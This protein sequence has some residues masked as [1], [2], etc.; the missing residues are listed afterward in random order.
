MALGLV[1]DTMGFIRYSHIYEGNIRDSKTLK[2][3]IKDMEE[4]YPSEGHCPVIVIDAGIATEE[5][6]RMLGAKEGLCM[7]IPCEDE[8]QSYS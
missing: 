4:R 3:T 1:T 5:N 7:C 8:R 2:K 6:L